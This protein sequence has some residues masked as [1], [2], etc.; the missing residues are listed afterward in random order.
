[1]IVPGWP[2]I[3]TATVATESPETKCGDGP[4]QKL[5]E[6]YLKPPMEHPLRVFAI[7]VIFV[8]AAI[9]WLAMLFVAALRSKRIPMC[10]RCGRPKVRRSHA[11]SFADEAL[12]M[13][14]LGPFRCT[15]CL[16]R[17]YAFR[18]KRKAHSLRDGAPSNGAHSKARPAH[19]RR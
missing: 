7:F 19:I 11:K 18:E 8:P 2:R 13:V 1:M 3:T 10:P 17:F 5:R 15:G 12:G 9:C 6:S 4:S 16:A 14:A